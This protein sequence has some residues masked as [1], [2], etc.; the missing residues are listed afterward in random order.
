MKRR[1]ARQFASTASAFA[2]LRTARAIGQLSGYEPIGDELSSAR[3]VRCS[4]E[5]SLA[6]RTRS[7]CAALTLSEC[8]ARDARDPRPRAK[9]PDVLVVDDDVDLVDTLCEMLRDAGCKAYAAC[10]GREALHW[11]ENAGVTPDLVLL[12]YAMPD[13]NGLELAEPLHQRWPQSEI[14][15]LTA[16]DEP[17]LCDEAFRE[18]VD[19]YLLKPVRASD[20][21][22][23]VE[24][25]ALR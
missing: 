3:V 9:V 2:E 7:V 24:G 5:S 20:V 6:D 15:I 11:A 1:I 18:H 22:Q 13:W 4:G 21:L 25:L 10:S 19:E 14:V 12:D 23:L 17:W 16:Y 8:I